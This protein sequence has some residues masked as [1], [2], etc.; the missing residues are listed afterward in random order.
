[1]SQTAALAQF[2]DPASGMSYTMRV[3]KDGADA[4]G[5]LGALNRVYLNIGLFSGGWLLPF[6]PFLGGRQITPIKISGAGKQLVY[7]Q[8][9]KDRTA[10]MALFF[11]VTAQPDRLKDAP[12][13]KAFLDP[14]DSDK[15]K[16][17][18]VVFAENCAACHSSKIP[19]IPAN[20]GID[21]GICA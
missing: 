8:G 10:D 6:P 2:W 3:L 11:L 18:Q 9:T 14:F 4:V 13:G 16:R 17:G 5:T 19:K 12:G 20:S 1:Y 21:D 15:V 7:W